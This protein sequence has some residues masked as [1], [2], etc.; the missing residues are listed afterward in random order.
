MLNRPGEPPNLVVV[1]C[2]H[3][4]CVV[5]LCPVCAAD[6]DLHSGSADARGGTDG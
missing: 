6:V 1:L 5:V 2:P 4:A 3:Q